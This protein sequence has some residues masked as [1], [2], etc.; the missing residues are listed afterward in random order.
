[1]TR[2]VLRLILALSLVGAWGGAAAAGQIGY[3]MR[4]ADK[5]FGYKPNPEPPSS[6]VMF[7]D[8]LVG[9][10]LG[11][12]ATVVGTGLFVV[13]TPLTL[14]SETTNEAAWGLVSRPGGWTL[15]RPLGRRAPLFEEPSV[16]KP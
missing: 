10:P 4:S 12:A 8:A 6:A 3:N 16:F 1:M 15:L 14:H 11:A 2:T 9:R 7:F 13:A 5:G